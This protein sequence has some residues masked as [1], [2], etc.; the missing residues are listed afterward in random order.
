MSTPWKQRLL[1]LVLLAFTLW[2]LVHM[3][4][5]RQLDVSPWKLGGWGMYSRPEL[6]PKVRLTLLEDGEW[7]PL[8][9]ARAQPAVARA[10]RRFA[11]WRR[12]LGALHPPDDL[13]ER[14]LEARPDIAGVDVSV[15]VG[16]L[17]LETDRIEARRSSYRY[18]RGTE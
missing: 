17:N 2:P 12:A 1:G 18:L 15:T 7:V 3:Q 14:I 16:E 5:V 8:Q 10:L 9:P 13:A 11:Y 4:L 6:L